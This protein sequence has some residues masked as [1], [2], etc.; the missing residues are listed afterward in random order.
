MSWALSIII[1][2]YNEE[3]RIGPTL[4]R[5]LEFLRRASYRAEVIVVDDGSK[6]QTAGVVA[7]RANDYREAGHGLRVLTNS[8][9]RGKGYSVRRG[10]SEALGDIILFTDAD[11]SSPITEA[12]KLID[13]IVAGRADVT[14]G[15]RALNRELIGVHQP[16]MREFGGKVFNLFMRII[17][18]LKFKDTQCGFKA[19]RRESALPVFTLQRIER[20]G[21]DAEVLYIAQRQG[22]RLLEVPVE[23]NHCE[24]GEL[25]SKLNYMRDSMNMFADLIRIRSNDITGRYS[26]SSLEIESAQGAAKRQ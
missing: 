3:T 20:F 1:P 26:D 25:Q 4:D 8:P 13:P 16:F 14:F 15:S 6:D 21:F 9:N 23:W 19:F 5:I 18:G 2:A 12:N 17:T 22:N 24:G 11:L 10:V 7:R